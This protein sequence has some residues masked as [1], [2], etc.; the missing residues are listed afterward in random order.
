MLPTGLDL[1]LRAWARRR[2]EPC[3]LL[4]GHKAS[5]PASSEAIRDPSTE[6]A[7]QTPRPP[8]GASALSCGLALDSPGARGTGSGRWAVRAGCS[9]PLGTADTEDRPAKASKGARNPPPDRCQASPKTA[10]GA[11]GWGG[12]TLPRPRS[13]GKVT[14]AGTPPQVLTGCAHS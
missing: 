6:R 9:R 12:R 14:A 1:E 11:G 13:L 10:P 4:S 3:C 7:P 8:D 2:P 5:L